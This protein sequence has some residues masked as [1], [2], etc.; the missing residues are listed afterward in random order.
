MDSTTAAGRFDRVKEAFW[1]CV[2]VAV[3]ALSI[4][5]VVGFIFSGNLIEIFRKNDPDV[6]RIGTTAL[7][8]QCVTFPLGSWVIMNNMLTQTIGKTVR[9]SLLAAA[10]QGLFFLP[11][12]LILPYIFGLTGIQSA[13]AVADVFAFILAYVLNRSVMKELSEAEEA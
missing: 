4:L 3:A 9:A 1:F 8:I 10:R 13:Q 5:A 2:K 12:I 11:A 6:I 7:R